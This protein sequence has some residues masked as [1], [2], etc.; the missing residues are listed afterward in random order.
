MNRGLAT[1]A[2]PVDAGRRGGFTLLEL[3]IV[4][5]LLAA[6]AAIAVP[7]VT[8][9]AKRQELMKATG[10]VM[11]FL[12]ENRRRAVEEGKPR[13]IRLE[14][15]G[16]NMVAGVVSAGIDHDV[17]LAEGCGFEKFDPAER[18]SEVAEESASRELVEAAWSPEATFYPDGTAS[19]FSFTVTGPGERRQDLV[20]RGLTGRTTVK[21]AEE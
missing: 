3:L 6:A 9:V 10:E 8:G 11:R 14:S 7:S 5:C 2:A 1:A 15:G 16:P 17:A 20:V 4:A 19:D 21:V 18:L 13:W 12:N